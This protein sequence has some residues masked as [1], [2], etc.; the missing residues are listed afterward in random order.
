MCISK[1]LCLTDMKNKRVN[2]K[3]IF[4]FLINKELL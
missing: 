2:H 1:M 4:K 3:I